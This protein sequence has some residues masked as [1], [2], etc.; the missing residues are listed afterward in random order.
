MPFAWKNSEN[1]EAL[2]D[3]HAGDNILQIVTGC[4]GVR[5]QNKK[6]EKGFPDY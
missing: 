6:N 3:Y 4:K 5:S 2:L 1:A